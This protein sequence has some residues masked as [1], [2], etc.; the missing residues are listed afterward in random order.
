MEKIIERSALVPY[1]A[2]QM[3]SLVDDI[4]LY[5]EFMEGCVGSEELLRTDAVVEARL[6]L[7][8]SKIKQSFVTR[9]KLFPSHRIEMTLVEGPFRVLE[10]VW[11]FEQLG[12][13]GCK[14]SLHLS[15]EFKNKILDLTVSP[16][17]ESIGGTLVGSICKRADSLYKST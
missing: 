12:D 2:E 15:F 4:A 10:G 11:Q 8:K 14:V 7:K 17:F 3:F 5:P 13:L 9:N 16:W 1:S 6:D